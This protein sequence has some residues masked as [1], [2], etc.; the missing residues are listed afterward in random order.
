MRSWVGFVVLFALSCSGIKQQPWTF[1]LPEDARWVITP[2]Q[3]LSLQQLS[4]ESYMR[5]LDPVSSVPLASLD[6]IQQQISSDLA[7]KSVAVVRSS[8][9]RN[10]TLWIFET[11]EEIEEWAALFYEPLT[12]NN[13]RFG[14]VDIHRLITPYGSLYA[15]NIHD[16]WI[17]SAYSGV[18]ERSLAAY[19]GG[20]YPYSAAADPSSEEWPDNSNQAFEGAPLIPVD[21]VNPAEQ[22]V[23]LQNL[24]EWAEQL[25]QIRYRPRIQG[26]TNGLS[27][28]KIQGILDEDGD[29]FELRAQL[30]LSDSAASTLVRSLTHS[31]HSI[32]L[33]R[34][35]A[36]NAAGFAIMHYPLRL[37]PNKGIAESASSLDSLLLANPEL[38]R[39]LALST[40]EEFGV[41]S[42]AESGVAATG[43]FLFMRLLQTP[44]IIQQQFELWA[45][46]GVVRKVDQSFYVQSALLAELFGGGLS[47][48]TDFYVNFSGEAVIMA[49]RK[50]LVETVEADRRRRRVVYYEDR[51]RE[52][53]DNGWEDLSAIAWFSSKDFIQFLAPMLMPEAPLQALLQGF[54]GAMMQIQRIPQ[55]NR[56]RFVLNSFT[57]EGQVQPYEELWVWPLSTDSLVATP[58]AV[59]VKGSSTQEVLATTVNGSVIAVA[60]DG[61]EVFR[62]QTEQDIP[63]GSPLVYDWYGNGQKIIMQAA[64]TKIYAWNTNESLLPQFPI[65]VGEQITTP[66]LVTDVLRNG[67]PELVVGTAA[68][69]VHV[70]DGRGQNVRGWPQKVNAAIRNAI[71]HT[72]WEDDWVLIVHAENSVHTWNSR[73][74]VKN[75]YPVFFPAPLLSDPLVYNEQ[76]RGTGADGIFYGLDT[77]PIWADSSR[78]IV[79]IQE[80][81]L[82]IQ[83]VS[84]SSAPL[85]SLTKHPSVLLRDSTGFY[86]KD[87]FGMVSEN[88]SVFLYSDDAELV[89]SF[90][91]GQSATSQSD[92]RFVDMDGD[93]NLDIGLAGNFGRLFAWTIIN[94]ER[95]FELPTASMRYPMFADLNGDGQQELVALTRDGLRCWTINQVQ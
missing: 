67:I 41:V 69:S 91:M 19:M 47:P 66:L 49:T 3:G 86:R 27:A 14:K 78:Q 29:G 6:F 36:S 50:G 80:D 16:Y 76:W 59:D 23:M 22:W 24:D 87:L 5:L 55:S 7:L 34:Y 35:I 13:Y 62:A 77:K 43:E 42:Y 39:G 53:L 45:E 73:G 85:I 94:Q 54:D 1:F 88:G 79:Q 90:T 68:R 56:A 37:S 58:I 8:S 21:R 95:L 64:G 17:V 33:D 2:Q 26:A 18:V 10:T 57:L 40:A 74:E 61:T 20:D 82:Q 12:Q 51:Y 44:R 4:Q 28:V 32:E 60:F 92:L 48:F 25:F 84:V 15:S 71:L 63:V 38:Y 89:A 11:D 93:N 81:S 46:Q 72:Q 31:N 65:E 83:G 9:T 52:L 30:S 70:L 75:G